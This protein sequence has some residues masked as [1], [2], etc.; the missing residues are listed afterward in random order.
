M[1]SKFKKLILFYFK[2]SCKLILKIKKPFIIGITGSAGKTT[3]KEMIFYVLEKYKEKFPEEFKE[4]LKKLKINFKDL[5]KNFIFKNY[6]SLNN[7]FG[8]PITIFLCNLRPG[9]NIL[10][11]LKIFLMSFLVFFKKYPKILVLE[12]GVERPGDMSFLMEFIRPNVGVFTILGEYPAHIGFFEK[13]EDVAK[14]KG[15][16]IERA[17]DFSILNFDDDLIK[18]FKD[19][20][21]SKVISFGY[22]NDVDIQILGEGNYRYFDRVLNVK[23]KPYDS[24]GIFFDLPIACSLGILKI[25]NGPEDII[26]EIENFKPLPG[27]LRIFER[28]FKNK[29]VYIFDDTYN[30]SPASY[31]YL[32][33][34][35]KKLNGKKIGIFADVLEV[36]NF[37]KEIHEKIINLINE[38]VDFAI[39]IGPRMK[40]FSKENIKI[41]NLIFQEPDYDKIYDSLNEDFDFIFIK[42]SRGFHL[43]NIVKKFDIDDVVNCFCE[44]RKNFHNIK[45]LP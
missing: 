31:F 8:I 32:L 20:T 30:A 24:F 12:L 15:I 34:L 21:K 28:N 10:N 39:L 4:N 40:I 23:V 14:E 36:D 19:K 33:N 44:Y 13:K 16:M 42:G 35:A 18:N 25:F 5:H 3:T 1:F 11:W 2:I 27:R 43:E 22:S 17:T 6:E 29:K 38:A 9:R 41:P 7:E 26:N 45:Y 37:A